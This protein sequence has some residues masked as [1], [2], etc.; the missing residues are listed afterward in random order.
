[1]K[2]AIL[3]GFGRFGKFF[4]EHF[5]D[6]FHFT[7]IDKNTHTSKSKN[8][9]NFRLQEAEIIFFATPISS[10]KEAAINLKSEINSSSLIVELC[11][12]KIYPLIVLKEIFPDNPIL[13]IHPLFGPD[14]VFNTL[15]GHQAILTQ[16]KLENENIHYILEAF[17]SKGVELFELTN[18]EHDKLM[19]YTLCL[20][21]FIGRSLGNFP[22]PEF[23]IGTKGYFD[24]LQIVKRTNADTLQLF[25]DMNIYNPYAQEM[26]ELLI[27]KMIETDSMINDFRRSID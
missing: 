2:N 6:H 20:T 22:L 17:Q 9:E 23:G 13:G 7:I 16:T 11:S 14:S 4:H 25:L 21:Q 1:M 12:V 15:K 10:L 5:Q 27:K 18:D 8:Q 19:A 26:R 3:I 24:L